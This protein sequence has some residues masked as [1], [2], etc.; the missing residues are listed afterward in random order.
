MGLLFAHPCLEFG[1][2]E[3]LARLKQSKSMNLS[4]AT[5]GARVLCGALS[6][7]R[8]DENFAANYEKAELAM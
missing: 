3:E 5:T 1:P 2:C 7:M 4:S 8:S 6:K